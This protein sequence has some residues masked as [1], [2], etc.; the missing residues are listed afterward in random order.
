MKNKNTKPIKIEFLR[1]NFDKI[2]TDHQK[3]YCVL[4]PE[5]ETHQAIDIVFGQ[6]HQAY[7][8]QIRLH[9]MPK[10]ADENAVT[11]RDFM[12]KQIIYLDRNNSS[13]CWPEIS[14]AI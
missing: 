14:S 3:E 2:L 6:A 8:D 4:H 10:A 12:L 5:V 7:L 11:E 13:D 1:I 9:C